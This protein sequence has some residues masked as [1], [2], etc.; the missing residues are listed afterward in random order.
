ME[1]APK[2]EKT[3]GPF[4]KRAV[5]N[6]L[7]D[8]VQ[9]LVNWQDKGGASIVYGENKVMSDMGSAAGAHRFIIQENG[10]LF[11]YDIPAKF[12]GSV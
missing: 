11:Y 6:R 10:A 8:V 5:F 9:A 4:A 1:G 2:L 3:T 7:V 12:I